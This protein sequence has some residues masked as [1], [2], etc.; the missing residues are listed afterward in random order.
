[1]RRLT[2]LTLFILCLA[3]TAQ[4]EP[5]SFTLFS[6]DLPQGWDG[7]ENMGFKSGNPD[8]CM[9]ILGLSNEKH[10]GYDAL[11]SIF[12]LPN[13]QKD[14]SA[15]LANKLAPLQANASTP[16]P[17]GPFWT[18]NGE[19]RSQ[20]FP[21]PGVTKVNT[22]SDKVFIAIVQDPQQRGA[23]AVFASLKGL[24]PEASKLLSQ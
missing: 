18:F 7:E 8:E 9:L 20:T 24:T 17:Q 21:A 10:D 19:P 16:R 15:A 11:I 23:E 13:E 4:A 6:A 3:V 12:V 14:D 1:M 2:L 5:R 22:T